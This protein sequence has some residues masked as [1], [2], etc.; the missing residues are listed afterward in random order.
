MNLQKEDECIAKFLTIIMLFYFNLIFNFRKCDKLPTFNKYAIWYQHT[1]NKT[2]KE[3]GVT[4]DRII[5][6]IFIVDLNHDLN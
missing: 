1:M 5:I 6:S 3:Y 4:N 2:M